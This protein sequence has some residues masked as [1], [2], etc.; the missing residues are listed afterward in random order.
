MERGKLLVRDKSFYKLVFTLAVPVIL[1]SMI[2]IGVNMMDTMML[3]SYG[4]VQLSASSLANEFINIF[5]ILCMGMGGGA[6]V[7]TAQYWGR[8]DIHALKRVVALMLRLCIVIATAFALA[9]WFFPDFLMGFYTQDAA[10]ID[11]G[12]L[13]F[14]ISALCYPLMGV[15]LTL[16][17]VLRSVRN[18]R[19]PL[20]SSIVAFF[21]N[22]FFNWVFIFGHLGAP[23]MQIEGAA[24]GTLIARLAE[25]GIIGGYFLFAD[26][27]IGFR[28]RDLF[29]S[30]KAYTA[31]FFKYSLPVIISDTL[32]ALGN[33]M[34]AIIMG[35]IG[36]SF[37]AANAIVSQTVRLSTV[38]N[39]GL[40]NA[41]GIITGNTL[42]A[43]ERDK[44]YRQGVTFFLLSIAIGVAA[45]GIILIL[46]PIFIANFNITADTQA[47]AYE[48]MAAVAVMVVFQTVQGVLTKGV[49][50][51]GGDTRF[52]MIADM[53][54]LWLVSVPAGY[55]A[56]LVLHLPAFWIYIA[57]K[58]DWAIK[59]IWCAFRLR[60]RKWIR[61][62]EDPEEGAA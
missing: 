36:A 10:I 51:G 29:V 11:K 5:Q 31:T 47:I 61:V 24:L 15:A 9:T 26:K 34:V 27:K 6:A 53:L 21:V 55:L 56:G 28:L 23:E 43:G 59:S 22:I 4:E 35:H 45:A 40:S 17:I 7:L 50:R 13:Y 3:G 30:C 44:A 33:N 37:V 32:L 57:L 46:C 25:C 12:A 60:S 49:L 16:T 14:R 42:G 48:L 20:I 8:Q 58:L 54:F 2:T 38:F 19:L 62:V 41:S 18:V 52:L 1:Q 39:Q